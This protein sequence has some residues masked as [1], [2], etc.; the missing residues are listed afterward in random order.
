ME[1]NKIL[2]PLD[3]YRK[4]IA[5]TYRDLQEAIK[6]E[7]NAIHQ[8]NSLMIST[9][10]LGY[11]AVQSKDTAIKERYKNTYKVLEREY[12]LVCDAVIKR[13]GYSDYLRLLKQERAE[14]LQNESKSRE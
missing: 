12:H 11:L 14:V 7:K 2:K 1:S 10:E 8:Y 6:Q 5:K 3:W 9:F 13:K 4:E